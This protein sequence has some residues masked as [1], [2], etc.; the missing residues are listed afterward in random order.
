[1]IVNDGHDN[2][3][4]NDDANGAAAEYVDD[5]HDDVLTM[6]TMS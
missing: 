1:M 3:D 4:H 2:D 5:G 6:T